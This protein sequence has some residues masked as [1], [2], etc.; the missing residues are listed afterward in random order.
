MPTQSAASDRTERVHCNTCGH[1]TNH[2]LLFSTNTSDTTI[3]ENEFEVG[4]YH[5]YSVLKCLGCDTICLRQESHFSEHDYQN[6]RTTFFPPQMARRAPEWLDEL[7]EGLAA[8]LREIYAAL[9]IESIRLAMMGARAALDMYI[10][11]KVGDVGSFPRKLAALADRG[12]I[13]SQHRQVL[14]AALDAG[15]AAAHRGHLPTQGEMGLV[16]DIVENVLHFAILDPAAAQLGQSIPP[17]SSVDEA[18]GA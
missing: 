16:M 18:A 2:E 8:L 12:L 15:N 10:T 6:I 4:W 1:A 14:E 17:R 7:D 9:Q 3:Y 13:S 11:A 5:R